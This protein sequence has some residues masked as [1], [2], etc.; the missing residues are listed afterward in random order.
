MIMTEK[1][2]K[3]FVKDVGLPLNVFDDDVFFDRLELFE[4]VYGAKTKWDEFLKDLSKF[5]TE[6]K[7]FEEVNRTQDAAIEYLKSINMLNDADMSNFS[8]P[9]IKGISESPYRE[10]LVG[11][12]L[13]S[14]DMKKANY[15]A[16]RHF[17][18]HDFDL[19]DTHI[20]CV[21]TSYEDF[22]SRWTKCPHLIKSKYMRQVIFGHVNPKRLQT[23]EK[24]LM[25]RL[26][27]CIRSNE[28]W[29][30]QR[31]TDV[32]S[33]GA[34]EIVFDITRFVDHTNGYVNGG[35]ISLINIILASFEKFDHIAFSASYYQLK[36]VP[37]CNGYMRVFLMDNRVDFKCV[38]ALD[39]PFAMRALLK[40]PVQETDCIFIH[41]GMRAKLLKQCPT[42]RNDVLDMKEAVA[43]FNAYRNRHY[44]AA[45]GTPEHE[46]ANV[47]NDFL[48]KCVT[49]LNAITKQDP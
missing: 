33:L 41:D 29:P 49:L 39:M 47:I 43:V 42:A 10:H 3:R 40:L 14:I 25:G 6:G 21:E 8:F 26:L 36:K 2:K 34:D 37:N 44:N 20:G 22:I 31:L 38:S 48:P 46:L 28:V 35:L 17:H 13:L 19:K 30:G 27:D 18:E 11:K 12:Y 45:S 9:V 15:T 4:P 16:F 23:Y 5:E 24:H 1:L 32:V 7:F